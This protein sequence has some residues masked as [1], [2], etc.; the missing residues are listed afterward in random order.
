M[1]VT[2]PVIARA[3]AAL[4]VAMPSTA[5]PRMEAYLE[6]LRK[7]NARIKLVATPEPETLLDRHVVDSMALLPHLP[8]TART[9]IDVGAGGGFPA[10]VLAICRPDLEVTAL[11]PVRK[12]HAFLSAVRRE[13]A[14]PNFRP[15]PER[16]EPGREP[17]PFDVAVS[18][19]TWPVPDWLERGRALVG[20]GGTV[21]AMEGREQHAL[22]PGAT[23]HPYGAG[24]R[25]RAIICYRPALAPAPGSG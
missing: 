18:R 14:L 19:A 15:R 17:G 3:A 7:W 4:G 16:L 5:A 10:A 11:E 20:P 12:K 21:L 2:G 6:L 23:R 9:L 1:S 13:L 25:T 8:A 22:P 24:D